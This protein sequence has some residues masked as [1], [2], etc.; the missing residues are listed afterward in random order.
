MKRKIDQLKNLA[1]DIKKIN[2]LVMKKILVNK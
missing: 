1:K 2:I